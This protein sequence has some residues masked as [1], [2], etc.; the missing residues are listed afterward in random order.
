MV[1]A[2]A[3]TASFDLSER[4]GLDAVSESHLTGLTAIAPDT[5]TAGI[6]TTTAAAVAAA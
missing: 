2:T 3:T 6:A 4:G 5:A 1:A